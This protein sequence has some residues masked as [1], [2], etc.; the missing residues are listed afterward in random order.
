MAIVCPKCR[1]AMEPVTHAGITVD[2]CVACGGLWFDGVEHL[3]LRKV[4]GAA[5]I[6]PGNPGEA[7]GDGR[8]GLQ[9]V[10]CPAC[11]APMEV[12]FDAYQ[13]HIHYE[14]CPN[15]NGAYFDAGEFRDFVTDDW[16]DFFKGLFT[17]YP[18]N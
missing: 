11:G 10:R 2:R 13:H 5:A 6:D 16:S 15:A 1:G 12:R 18:R 14:T 7:P 9:V 3:E 17:S 4:P 8:S